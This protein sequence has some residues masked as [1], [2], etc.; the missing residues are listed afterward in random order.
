MLQ[1]TING[2]LVLG[3]FEAARLTALTRHRRDECLARMDWRSGSRG[4]E[5]SRRLRALEAEARQAGLLPIADGLAQE[6]GVS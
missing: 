5:T 2:A 1:T 3:G 4:E 6:L